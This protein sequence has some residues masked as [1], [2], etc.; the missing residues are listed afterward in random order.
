[1][2]QSSSQGRSIS[3]DAPSLQVVRAYTADF[4]PVYPVRKG[5]SKALHGNASSQDSPS[6]DNALSSLPMSPLDHPMRT[7]STTQ[8]MTPMSSPLTSSTVPDQ[9]FSSSSQRP[10]S[11]LKHSWRESIRTICLV[12][13]LFLYRGF[14]YGMFDVLNAQFRMAAGLPRTTSYELHAAEF[15]GY[16]LAPLLVARPFLKRLGMKWTFITGLAIYACGALVFWPA[17]VLVN[18]AAFY[19]SNFLVGSGLAVLDT[20]INLFVCVCGPMEWAEIRLN[21]VRGCQSATALASY[22]LCQRA[23]FLNVNDIASLVNVQWAYLTMS[24]ISILVFTVY[25]YLPIPEA[26]DEELKDLAHSR[27]ADFFGQVCGLRVVWVTL[28]L[29][30]FSLFCFFGAQECMNTKNQTFV[31]ANVSK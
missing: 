19:V 30:T 13:P 27:E 23:L 16:A 5:G 26:P 1:M 17:A 9:S 24:L 25:Y 11:L 4:Q 2:E 12:L 7:V 10:K 6:I 3:Q 8:A 15:C 18:L 31:Q 20:S 22:L 29:G 21:L 28:V 14:A